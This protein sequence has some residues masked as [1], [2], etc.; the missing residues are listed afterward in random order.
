MNCDLD[1]YLN[2]VKTLAL[3]KRGGF[4]VRDDAAD[5]ARTE[6]ALRVAL[7]KVQRL[8]RAAE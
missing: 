1:V 8:I 5:L 2:N 7:A 6:S 4:F 3:S